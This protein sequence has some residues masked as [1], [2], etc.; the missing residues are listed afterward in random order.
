[1]ADA[2]AVWGWYRE[3]PIISRCYLTA[4]VGVTIA[5][6][7]DIVSPLSLY[8]NYDLVFHKGQYWRILTSFLFYG[9][10]SLDFVFHMYFVMRY[11]WLL[12]EGIFRGRPADFLFMI[13]L[14]G[15]A[16][17]TLTACFDVFSRIRFLGHPLSFMMVYLWSRDPNNAH[18]RMAFFVLQFNAPILPWVMLTFSLILGNPV[19]TDL[20]GILVGHSY[21]F[22]DQVY[23]QIAEVRGW[24]WKKCLRTPSFLDYILQP[25]R[26]YAYLNTR[27]SDPPP[28]V[29]FLLH[30][31][32]CVCC[33][34]QVVDGPLPNG[35]VAAD[36]NANLPEVNADHPHQD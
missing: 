27:V 29:F 32:R 5:C 2:N 10:F 34:L 1:M 26:F 6:Y 11:A 31:L 25:E 20:L 18:V 8:Y 15:T 36:P 19:E 23:P 28:R 12:E 7:L 30:P 9:T 33:C 14:G 24:R 4:A 35:A 17:L 21:Y 13:I 3:I 16:L 22:L